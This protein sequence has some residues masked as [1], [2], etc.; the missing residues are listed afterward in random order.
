MRARR[1][2]MDSNTTARPRWLNSDG[3]AALGLITAPS[4][5]RLPFEHPDSGDRIR[6]LGK[7]TDDIAVVALGRGE[8]L[9]D[10]LAPN[11]GGVHMQQRRQLLHDGRQA[12]GI[13]QILHQK[14]AGGLQVDQQRDVRW[15]A[16]R[17][18]RVRAARRAG[19]R[20]RADA[21]RHWWSRR[22]RPERG[23]RSRTRRESASSTVARLAAPC[24]RSGG[25]S[26]ARSCG[27]ARQRPELSHC[28]AGRRPWLPSGKQ[29]SRHCPWSCRF[30]LC[31]TCRTPPP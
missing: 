4:G 3:L 1:S 11:G 13:V 25:R 19:R 15:T 22:W 31:A 28:R 8:A 21:E 12:A 29:W 20:W 5:Q 24:S 16:G 14:P 7:S 18:P 2:S 23:W 9:A 17:S 10:R 6:G 30:R 27:A 26:H